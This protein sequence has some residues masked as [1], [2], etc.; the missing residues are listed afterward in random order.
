[1]RQYNK[2]R[3]DELGMSVMKAY[4]L[5]YPDAAKKHRERE[6]A[7][8]KSNPEVRER[9]R[10]VNRAHRQRIRM[11]IMKVY[12]KKCRCCGERRLPFLTFDHPNNDGAVHRRSMGGSSTPN[13]YILY[14]WLKDNKFPKGA[15]VTMCWNCNC[16]RA[17]NGGVCPHK[18]RRFEKD[19]K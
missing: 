8:Y 16:G 10:V 19:W 18:D 7:R 17:A 2:R 15:L 3:K 11:E 1:M 12:G 6:K 5:K 4:R 14:R 13:M 9:H